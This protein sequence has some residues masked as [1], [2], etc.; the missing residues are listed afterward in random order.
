MSDVLISTRGLVKHFPIL[1]GV[2]KRPLGWVRAVDSIS[3]SIRRGETFGLVGE[4]GCGKTTTG[5]CL[6][7]LIEASDGHI[8]YNTAMRDAE[9]VEGLLQTVKSENGGKARRAER[10][11][12]QLCKRYGIELADVSHSRT[13]RSQIVEHF[14]DDMKRIDLLEAQGEDGAALRELAQLR[15]RYDLTTFNR[16]RMQRLRRQMQIIFQDPVAS[17]NPRFLVKDIVAEPLV[18]HK[19]TRGPE[20]L[21]RVTALLEQVGLNPEHLFRYPHEFSGGQRQRIAIARALAL[22]PQFLVLDEPT[23]ALDVSVQAQILNLLKELQRELGLTYLFISH[24]LSVVRHMADR[25]GVMYVGKLVEVASKRDIFENPLHPYTQ[26]LLEVIPVPDPEARKELVEVKGEVPSPADP[27]LGCR[28]H[29]RCP[30]AFED[31]GWEGRDLMRYVDS[32]LKPKNPE[33]PLV[34]ALE[35]TE[36]EGFRARIWLDSQEEGLE[37]QQRLEAMAKR[38][39][40]S[41]ALFK[42]MK[43]TKIEE[44]SLVV[45]FE[46]AEEP[47]LKEVKKGHTV[48]CHLY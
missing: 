43:G 14:G 30:K 32:V 22:N 17:L 2:F 37:I 20:T 24:H 12:G 6:L 21:D 23:S 33:D 18:I 10:E 41:S 4:S 47:E 40:E 8:Y 42:A 3:F 29:P 31:C 15:K 5:R 16:R 11:L 34:K 13:L 9:K 28:F 44:D 46:E 1:G 38:E 19:L 35:R 25:V 27:P 26:S 7:K 45:E 36:R 48:A 39:K